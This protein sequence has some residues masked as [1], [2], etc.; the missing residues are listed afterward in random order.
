MYKDEYE[1]TLDTNQLC[2]VKENRSSFVRSIFSTTRSQTQ[3][4]VEEEFKSYCNILVEPQNTEPA[5]WWKL[6]Q[7]K[8]PKLSQ[9]A[10]DYLGIPASS[11]DAERAFSSSGR[12]V[13]PIRSSLGAQTI[14][15]LQCCKSWFNQLVV[16]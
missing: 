1:D 9:M 16:E 8:F 6:N 2:E 3:Q 5:T 7:A 14:R 13:V 12:T 10:K 11:V 4:T 15:A